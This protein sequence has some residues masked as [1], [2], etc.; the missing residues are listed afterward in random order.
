MRIREPI[1]VA[2]VFGPG[3]AVKP[4]WFDWHNRKHAVLETTYNW[5][6]LKGNVRRLH[7][8]VRDEGGLYEL[9][10]NTQDQTWSLEGLDVTA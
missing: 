8:A 2:V 5:T 3:G 9:I 7:F 6:D 4:I 1:R 10:Y